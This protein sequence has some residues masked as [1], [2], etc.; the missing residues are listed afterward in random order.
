[1]QTIKVEKVVKIV[2]K[3]E[4]KKD[5]EGSMARLGKEILIIL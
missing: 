4:V 5:K 3:K 1:M 2:D